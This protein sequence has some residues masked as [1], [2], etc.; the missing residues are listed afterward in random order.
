MYL[1]ANF[2]VSS[3]PRPLPQNEPLKSSPR[4]GLNKVK[5]HTT[6][7]QRYIFSFTTEAATRGVLLKKGVLRNFT[8]FT[9]KHLC[10]SLFLN[11]FAVL[12]PAHFIKKETIAQ[13]F[14]SEF[15]EPLDNCFCY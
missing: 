11:K 3:P 1:R 12:K 4:L 6:L 15:C 5:P 10:Q 13:V 9:G 8:K 7:W 2:Q 14:S